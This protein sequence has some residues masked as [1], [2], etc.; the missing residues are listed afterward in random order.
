MP[1]TLGHDGTEKAMKLLSTFGGSVALLLLFPCEGYGQAPQHGAFVAYE[2]LEMA[3][4]EFRYFAGEAGYQFGPKYRA[5][6]TVM[7]VDLTERHLS[8]SWEAGAVDGEDVVGYFRGYEA[9]V[10]RFFF[11]N[12]YASGSLGYY[13]DSYEHTV[14]DESLENRTLTIGSGIGY[15]RE[16]LLGVRHLYLDF[17]IPVRYYFNQIEETEWGDATVRPHVVVNNIWLFVGYK[18]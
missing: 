8:S 14:L 2:V 18:F 12:W 6:L 11:R 5:R 13:Q 17:N 15:R 7:E 9:H 3:M 16:N 1:S 10:D 4:N